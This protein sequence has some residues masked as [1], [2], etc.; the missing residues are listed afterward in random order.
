MLH[1]TPFFS[2]H[3]HSVHSSA[4][5]LHHFSFSQCQ[6][7]PQATIDAIIPLLKPYH[8]PINTNLSSYSHL[9]YTGSDSTFCLFFGFKLYVATMNL[10]KNTSNSKPLPCHLLTRIPPSLRSNPNYI[11]TTSSN[12][13]LILYQVSKALLKTLLHLL[14][15][16]DPVLLTH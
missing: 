9:Y 15:H 16:E 13:D 10:N 8:L 5:Y 2:K 6:L 11:F 1:Y 4:V 7:N 12:A 14:L 3:T